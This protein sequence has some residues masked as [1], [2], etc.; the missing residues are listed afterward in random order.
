[1]EYK[2]RFGEEIKRTSPLTRKQFDIRSKEDA[3]NPRTLSLPGMNKIIERA[4]TTAGFDNKQDDQR[5]MRSNG[6]RKFAITAMKKA[7][8]DFSDREYLVGPKYG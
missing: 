2:K 7:K 3:N 6:F 4:L 1:L 8:V 5:P